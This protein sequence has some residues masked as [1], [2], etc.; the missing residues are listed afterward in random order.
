MINYKILKEQIQN[1][2]KEADK[3]LKETYHAEGIDNVSIKGITEAWLGREAANDPQAINYAFA[4]GVA[5]RVPSTL[6]TEADGSSVLPSHFSNISGWLGSVGGL[7]QAAILRGYEDTEFEA[8]K[9]IPSYPVYTNEQKLIRSY[10]DGRSAEVEVGEPV[11]TVGLKEAYVS[12]PR[13]KRYGT[14]CKINTETIMMDL[15]G[16][17]VENAA[18]CGWN[19]GYEK[20]QKLLRT[21]W[22][23][24]NTYSRNGSTS[25]TYVVSGGAFANKLDQQIVDWTAINN[26]WLLLLQNKQPENNLPM[27]IPLSEAT[28]WVM[29]FKYQDTQHLLRSTT[30][31]AGTSSGVLAGQY[32]R[33]GDNPLVDK[34][35]KLMGQSIMSYNILT[36][37]GSVDTTKAKEYFLFGRPERAFR[38]NELYPLQVQQT[39]ISSDD[40]RANVAACYVAQTMFAPVVEEPRYIALGYKA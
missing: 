31:Y 16:T 15:S 32:A 37:D 39:V 8:S 9:I 40:A 11:P 24:D 19:V 10:I 30:V 25:N 1:N 22:G 6:I 36:V 29:P 14:S 27:S 26:L 20:E 5:G 17:V 23:I 34:G 2:P 4:Q 12:T 7:V 38:V 33:Q 13:L 18:K 3:I 35:I 21:I 28:V